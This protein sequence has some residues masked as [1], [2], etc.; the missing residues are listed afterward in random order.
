MYNYDDC[1][2][3]FEDYLDIPA[4]LRPDYHD[5]R[6]LQYIKFNT[7]DSST[8]CL[9]DDLDISSIGVETSCRT[10]NEVLEDLAGLD[11]GKSEL[12]ILSS[13][14]STLSS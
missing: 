2:I 5:A 4:S 8:I 11:D 10:T 1:V 14:H 13:E 9:S 12:F 3:A 7:P 6:A